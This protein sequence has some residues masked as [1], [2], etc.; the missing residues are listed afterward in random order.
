[1]NGRGIYMIVYLARDKD[2]E[3]C[4]Y[5][6]KPTR[7]RRCF[8]SGGEGRLVVTDASCSLAHLD[9]TWET[10]PVAFNLIRQGES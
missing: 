3:L 10:E 1:M 5:G 8:W 9:I 7:T 4:I 6:N 2:N